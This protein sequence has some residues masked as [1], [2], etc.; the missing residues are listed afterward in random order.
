[1]KK[2]D[3]FYTSYW[4][5]SAK[6]EGFARNI[7]WN[8]VDCSKLGNYASNESWDLIVREMEHIL[9]INYNEEELLNIALF[10]FELDDEEE[11]LNCCD[12]IAYR[13][14]A[15]FLN[16]RYFYKNVILKNVL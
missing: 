15:G 13:Y 1:M 7:A 6:E 8:V 16:D 3:S 10:A 2:T 11:M 5:N 9:L 14:S 12:M 4:R